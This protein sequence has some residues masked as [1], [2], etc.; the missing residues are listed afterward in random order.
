MNLQ[1]AKQ[2][3]PRNPTLGRITIDFNEEFEN[4]EH[5]RDCNCEFGSNE[6][7][8]TIGRMQ[9]FLDNEAQD[10]REMNHKRNV[11]S[12]VRTVQD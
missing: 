6:S 7:A 11:F 3:E 2:S 9:S 4:T 10:N 5:S 1:S 12:F 8:K